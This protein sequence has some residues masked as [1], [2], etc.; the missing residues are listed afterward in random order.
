MSTLLRGERSESEKF[1]RV[2]GGGFLL[3]TLAVVA[4]FT[5]C[6]IVKKIWTPSWVLF[7]G[8]YEI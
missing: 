1:R 8:A 4:S 3:L 7:S 2:I 5:V 6:P